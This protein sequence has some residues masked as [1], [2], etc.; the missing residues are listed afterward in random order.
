LTKQHKI[1]SRNVEIRNQAKVKERSVIENLIS[2]K[3]T[4]PE[5]ITEKN[6]SNKITVFDPKIRSAPQNNTY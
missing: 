4:T 5:A 3:A 1:N 2:F 6:G